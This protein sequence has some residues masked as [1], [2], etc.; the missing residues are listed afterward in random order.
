MFFF[1]WLSHRNA[2]RAAN[3]TLDDIKKILPKLST[4]EDRHGYAEI[5]KKQT[6]RL[7]KFKAFHHEA[8]VN[9]FGLSSNRF[10]AVEARDRLGEAVKEASSHL[11]AIK[12]CISEGKKIARVHRVRDI[13]NKPIEAIAS[14]GGSIGSTYKSVTG[15]VSNA[16][17]SASTASKSVRG[18]IGRAGLVFAGATAVL[19][20][21]IGGVALLVTGKRAEEKE[22]SNESPY[23]GQKTEY[24]RTATMMGIQPTAGEL[25]AQVLT[26]RNSTEPAISSYVD[27]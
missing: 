5:L 7:E 9:R 19:T 13:I 20:A 26:R 18:G 1:G 14:I 21:A 25:A 27:R 3:R 22:T 12:S 10:A 15:G 4:I 2:Q 24:M 17:K 8:D 6:E 11:K 23:H 16:F